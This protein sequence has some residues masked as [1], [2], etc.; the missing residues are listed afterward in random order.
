MENMRKI[1]HAIK[2]KNPDSKILIGYAPVIQG[3]CEK[4]G[5]DFYSP[6]Q[7]A[8]NFLKQL[9]S[10]LNNC[11]KMKTKYFLSYSK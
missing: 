5:S 11:Y 7:G 4:I 1:V 2:Q 10:Q 9:V 6:N 3:Y 8:V